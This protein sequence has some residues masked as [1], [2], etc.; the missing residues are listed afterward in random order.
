MLAPRLDAIAIICHE[1]PLA[2]HSI[3]PTAR[4]GPIGQAH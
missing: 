1:G 3:P 2:A 4:S